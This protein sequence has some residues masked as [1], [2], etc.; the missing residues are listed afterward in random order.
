[1]ETE[2][3]YPLLS[4]SKS[5]ILLDEAKAIIS[6]VNDLLKNHP[7][8]SKAD[9]FDRICPFSRIYDTDRLSIAMNQEFYLSHTKHDYV[10]RARPLTESEAEAFIIASVG[11]N[12]D[13]DDLLPEGVEPILLDK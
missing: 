6:E 13:K 8:I 12:P 2:P 1:M 7:E 5:D 10:K 11:I 3:R 4:L 9:A